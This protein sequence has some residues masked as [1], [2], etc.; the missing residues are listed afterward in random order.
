M[1]SVKNPIL[2]PTSIAT[3]VSLQSLHSTYLQ[4]ITTGN[5]HRKRPHQRNGEKILTEE[6][7]R[8]KVNDF[9]PAWIVTCDKSL[10]TPLLFPTWY[11]I[12]ID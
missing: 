3:E 10:S 2:P 1:D 11:I 6:A 8:I 5:L 12:L 9:I 4:N 7:K